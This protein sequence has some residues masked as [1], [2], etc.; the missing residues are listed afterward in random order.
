[1]SLFPTFKLSSAVSPEFF[2]AELSKH[3]N[4]GVFGKLLFWP[5]FLFRSY[6]TIFFGQVENRHFL[7]YRNTY[8][9][10]R[11]SV[12]IYGDIIQGNEGTQI[13]CVVRPSY[14]FYILF[15]FLSL[16]FAFTMLPI[17]TFDSQPL[18]SRIFFYAT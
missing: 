18:L 11:G 10:H 5:W 14:T 17:M 12:G 3:V 4:S 7:I 8:W 9:S 2:E 6:N 13:S 16:W 15:A 1:M